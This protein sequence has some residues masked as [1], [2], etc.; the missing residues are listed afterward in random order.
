[1]NIVH[2]RPGMIFAPSSAQALLGLSRF[3]LGSFSDPLRGNF[4]VN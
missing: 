3:D 2:D 1:M 4:V